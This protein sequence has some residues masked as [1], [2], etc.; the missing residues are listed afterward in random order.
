MRAPDVNVEDSDVTKTLDNLR[1][2][3]TGI[4]EQRF[5]RKLMIQQHTQRVYLKDWCYDP[6]LETYRAWAYQWPLVQV[7]TAGITIGNGGSWLLTD[8]PGNVLVSYW[9]GY[10]REEHNL[11]V[12]HDKYSLGDEDAQTGLLV[13]PGCIPADLCTL[14]IE[15]AL[16]LFAEIGKGVGSSERQ[17]DIVNQVITTRGLDQFWVSNRVNDLYSTY[18]RL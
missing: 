10:R 12:L 15:I 16:F 8:D 17:M 18:R 13:E 9:S 6:V 4:I 11:E 5:D 7:D 3:A 1:R 2:T 14:A